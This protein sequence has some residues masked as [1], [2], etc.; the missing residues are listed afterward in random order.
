MKLPGWLKVLLGVAGFLALLWLGTA[1]FFYFAFGREP[2]PI[3]FDASLWSDPGRDEQARYAMRQG[4]QPLL[5]GKTQAEAEALL[6]KPDWEG[7]GWYK[8]GPQPGFGIDDVWLELTYQ[9]GKVS[10]CALRYD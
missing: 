8:L 3:P 9:D 6:G 4:L 10:A 5:I 2:A 1:A 7:R